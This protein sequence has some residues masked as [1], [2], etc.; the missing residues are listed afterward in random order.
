MSNNLLTLDAFKLNLP[1]PL[2]PAKNLT[3]ADKTE[4]LQKA[5]RT[6]QIFRTHTEMMVGVL[7]QCDFPTKASKYWQCVREQTT[8]LEA[9]SHA[10]LDLRRTEVDI[11]RKIRKLQQEDLDDL[12]REDLEVELDGLFIKKALLEDQIADRIREIRLW[13]DIK[14]ELDD[15]SFD[16]EDPNTDQLLTL[17]TRMGMQILN[18]N[19]QTLSTHEATNL[20]GQFN[21][22]LE[23]CKKHN[24]LDKVLEV[25]PPTVHKFIELENKNGS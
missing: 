22:A 20:F 11:K 24:L 5:L 25:L 2:S 6:R 19:I 14:S 8:M 23:M 15:G 1:A 21:A 18:I 9:L 4:E 3:L 17:T 7:Q 13:S 16:T 10:N 12:D